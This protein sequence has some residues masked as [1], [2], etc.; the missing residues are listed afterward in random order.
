MGWNNKTKK[1]KQKQQKKRG[2]FVIHESRIR[3]DVWILAS[4]NTVVFHDSCIKIRIDF[5]AKS[6]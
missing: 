6:T 3:D 1:Q 5:Y 4:E 2:T